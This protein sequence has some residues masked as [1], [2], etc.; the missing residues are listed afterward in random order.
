M[1]RLDGKVAIVTGGGSGLG[2][3]M[4]LRYLSEGACVLAADINEAGARETVRL[5]GEQG[6]DAGERVVARMLDVT[7]EDAVAAAVEET[8][9]RWGKLD[10][11]VA[12]AG[13]GWPAPIALLELAQWESVLKVDLTGVFLCAKHAFRALRKNGDSGGVILAT[14]SVAGMEGTPNLGAYGPAKAGVIQLMKTVALE[15]A[16][17]NIRANAIC[18][19]W[20]NTPMVQAFVAGMPAG[21]EAGM[22]RLRES[23]PLG[24]VGAPEDVAAVAAFLASDDAAFLTGMTFPVDGGHTAGSLFG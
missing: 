24:R 11:M 21:P 2:R 20:I 13:I 14:A 9:T 23:V 8:V 3:A 22:E 6:G 7:D 1:G 12:N 4:T 10:I 17:Y 19:V 15:G 5:G 16:R 18:P